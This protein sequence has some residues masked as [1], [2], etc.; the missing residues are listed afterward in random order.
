MK[1]SVAAISGIA[2]L[3]TSV[4]AFT[5]IPRGDSISAV[6]PA[7]RKLATALNMSQDDFVKSEIG[8]NDVVVFSKTY[9][10]YCTATKALFDSLGVKYAVHELDKMGDDGPELQTALLKMTGQRTVPSVFVKGS[11]IGGNDE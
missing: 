8:S 4:A 9:C 10:P 2:L 7:S 3:A 1:Y 5:A 6:T 11:H